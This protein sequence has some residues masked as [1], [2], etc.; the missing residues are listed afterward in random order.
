MHIVSHRGSSLSSQ[1]HPIHACAPV[2]CVVVVLFT[3]LLF[4]FVPLLFF[5]TFQMSSSEF[6]ERLKSK[7]L[8]DFRLGTV[9]SSDHET[10]LTHNGSRHFRARPKLHKKPREACK[11]SWSP[12]GILKSFTLTIPWN[13]AKLVK[14]SG[15]IARLHHIDRR[16]MGLLKEQCAE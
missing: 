12:I 15:I 10:P 16:L 11:R 6:H 3:R 14:I 7:D 4:L 1:R 2:R 13:S 9:A 8:R 5:Q